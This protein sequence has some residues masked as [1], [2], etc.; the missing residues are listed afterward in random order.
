MHSSRAVPAFPIDPRPP[1]PACPFSI[2]LFFRPA[3]VHPS[4]AQHSTAQ[5]TSTFNDLVVPLPSTPQ[6][7]SPFAFYASTT[8]AP[9]TNFLGLHYPYTHQG[10]SPNPQLPQSFASTTSLHIPNQS[11]KMATTAMDYENANGD[12]FDG[13]S[14]SSTASSPFLYPVWPLRQHLASAPAPDA[15]ADEQ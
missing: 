1:L 10:L 5:H 2:E 12:R 8:F 14:T 7:N 6:V 4:T 13:M 11:S 15:D 9:S 3:R